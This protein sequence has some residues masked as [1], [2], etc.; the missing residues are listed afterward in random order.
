MLE[1]H[2]THFVTELC[3]L[4]NEPITGNAY[5][6]DAQY[7]WMAFNKYLLLV[8]HPSVTVQSFNVLLPRIYDVEKMVIGGRNAFIRITRK[9]D[10]LTLVERPPVV[11]YSTDEQRREAKKAYFK[12]YN[13]TKRPNRRTVAATRQEPVLQPLAPAYNAP[14]I[15]DPVAIGTNRGETLT[16]VGPQLIGMV[17][18]NRSDSEDDTDDEEE[19]DVDQSNLPAPPSNSLWQ[20]RIAT[21]SAYPPSMPK[22]VLMTPGKEPSIPTPVKLRIVQP[23]KS[24]SL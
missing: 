22:I 23:V 8:G 13:Q 4:G 21:L 20:S 16:I 2:L 24:T 15:S 18:A 19:E 3:L 14:V 7:L 1:Q 11:V 17:H 12:Q 10:I 5:R 6:L 9:D